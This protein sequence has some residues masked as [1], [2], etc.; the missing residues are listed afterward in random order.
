[1]IAEVRL[2]NVVAC[3]VDKAVLITDLPPSNIPRRP[4]DDDLVYY[5]PHYFV[6]D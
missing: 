1:M 2:P 5:A 6:G 3:R 4:E